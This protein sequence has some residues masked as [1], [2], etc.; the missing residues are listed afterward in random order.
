SAVIGG[1]PANITEFPWQVGILDKGSHICGG[2]I[3]SEWW[4]LS[5]SHCFENTNHSNLAIVHGTD[6]LEAEEVESVGVDLIIIH[7]DYDSAIYN[8]DIA[9]LLLKTPL[10]FDVTRMPVHL[11]EVTDT[12]AWTTCWVTG[13][14]VTS[15]TF[16]KTSKLQK[17]KLDL[18][19]WEKC[20]HIFPLFTTNMICAGSSEDGKDACQGDSGGPLVCRKK[21]KKKKKKKKNTW[22]QLGIVSW[23]KGCAKKDLPGVYTKVSNYLPWINGETTQAGMP[24][25]HE[26]DSGQ[27]WLLSPLVILFLYF[28]TLLLFW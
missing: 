24:Y 12:Q 27:R 21:K 16:T 10:V 19:Q 28:L 20:F 22:Y 25:S 15:L 3:L 17:V 7:P 4:I 8:N 18:V 23:G 9:L 6:N 26:P 2:S 13:W 5:A 14:G 1:D 11:S